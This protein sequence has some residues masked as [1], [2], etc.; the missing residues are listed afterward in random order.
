MASSFGF[1]K[2]Q[3][4]RMGVRPGYPERADP[5][6]SL[7]GAGWP[8]EG[9]RAVPAS[10]PASGGVE[11]CEQGWGRGHVPFI[12]SSIGV[13]MTICAK[14]DRSA[15]ELFLSPITV[16]TAPELECRFGGVLESGLARVMIQAVAVILVLIVTALVIAIPAS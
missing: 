2:L 4:L 10:S 13:P 15:A 16:P 14:S 5:A 8:V 1:G 7:G 9:P 12:R 6:E 3:L 11:R